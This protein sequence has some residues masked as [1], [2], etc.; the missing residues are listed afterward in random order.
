MNNI[1]FYMV[2]FSK[3]GY[4]YTQQTFNSTLQLLKHENKHPIVINKQ[5]QFEIVSYFGYLIRKIGKALHLYKGE[6]DQK[7]IDLEVTKFMQ[8]HSQLYKDPPKTFVSH[9]FS[10][11]YQ[12]LNFPSNSD[13]VCYRVKFHLQQTALNLIQELTSFNQSSSELQEA[14]V[15]MN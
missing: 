7:I 2:I 1:G 14:Q 10:I 11:D 3:E 15:I 13:N 5:G 9:S 12:G 8:F 4:L 6:T